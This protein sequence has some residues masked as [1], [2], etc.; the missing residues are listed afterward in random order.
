ML[1]FEAFQIPQLCNISGKRNDKFTSRVH[2]QR[3]NGLLVATHPADKIPRF[4]IEA[5]DC[6]VNG[7]H[8]VLGLSFEIVG[9]CRAIRA[10]PVDL[11]VTIVIEIEHVD[12]AVDVACQET[13]ALLVETDLCEVYRFCA[14][15][16]LVGQCVLDA[17]KLASQNA[18][19]K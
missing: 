2:T 10:N 11:H 16:K 13:I 4:D 19:V 6:A 15:R 14:E 12:V 8:Q 3:Y 7:G 9:Q 1:A 18:N 5:F 17:K